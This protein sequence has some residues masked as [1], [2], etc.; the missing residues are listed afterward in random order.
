MFQSIGDFKLGY[1]LTIKYISTSKETLKL[2]SNV[3][4]LLSS[5]EIQLSQKH[6]FYLS[7]SKTTGFYVPY[8]TSCLKKYGKYALLD[9]QIAH[10]F[11][12]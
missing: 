3:Q 2:L 6:Q 4:I 1:L 7:Q 9:N 12:C 5:N 11:T 8:F 10:I